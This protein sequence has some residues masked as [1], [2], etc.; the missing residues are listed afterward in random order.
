MR[1]KRV[2]FSHNS[3]T[4]KE[5]EMLSPMMDWPVKGK[6]K[7]KDTNAMKITATYLP[8]WKINI[9]HLLPPTTLLPTEIIYVDNPH[10]TST[11]KS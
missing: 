2:Y 6:K 3:F 4:K 9:Y 1:L 5:R 8:T 7:K 10:S 11:L